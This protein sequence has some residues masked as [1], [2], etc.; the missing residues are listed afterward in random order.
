[1]KTLGRDEVRLPNRKKNPCVRTLGVGQRIAG[2]KAR[3]AG[4]VSWRPYCPSVK[5]TWCY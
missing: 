5:L 2:T 3:E 4:R 1:M